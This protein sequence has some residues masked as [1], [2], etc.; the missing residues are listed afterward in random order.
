M[1]AGY[2]FVDEPQQYVAARWTPS[3]ARTSFAPSRHNWPQAINASG[4][5]ALETSSGPLRWDPDNS[6]TPLEQG[7]PNGTILEGINDAATVA[8][9]GYGFDFVGEAVR[10]DASGALTVLPGVGGSV[11]VTDINEAGQM[12][13]S[14]Y[15]SGEP[16]PLM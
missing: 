15:A 12:I 16:Q 1:V 2:Y 5:I 3:G 10:W 13:G 14:N 11:A 9:T 4:Q 7:Y 6:T 8:G